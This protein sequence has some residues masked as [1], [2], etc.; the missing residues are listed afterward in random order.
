MQVSRQDRDVALAFLGHG[1]DLLDRKVRR[2]LFVGNLG[3][4]FEGNVAAESEPAW[5]LRRA[6]EDRVEQAPLLV[7]PAKSGLLDRRHRTLH[8]SLDR[9]SVGLRLCVGSRSCKLFAG[10]C[11]ARTMRVAAMRTYLGAACY[12]VAPLHRTI[13]ARSRPVGNL[14]SVAKATAL[15]CKSSS[16]YQCVTAWHGSCQ[17]TRAACRPAVEG[18]AMINLTDSALNAVRQ[19][20]L[21]G[22]QARSAACASWSRPAAAPVTN[23]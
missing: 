14:T 20:D 11:G 16:I 22:G 21:R 12:C 2:P 9:L 8:I 6:L 15:N 5:L 3:L 1:E 7:E 17:F 10:L 23:T 18:R 4:E 19:R 13:R